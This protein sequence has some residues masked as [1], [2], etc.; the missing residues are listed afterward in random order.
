MASQTNFEEMTLQVVTALNSRRQL[1][2]IPER[3][4]LVDRLKRVETPTWRTFKRLRELEINEE[5]ILNYFKFVNTP[6]G[7][8]IAAE[9]ISTV[10]EPIQIIMPTRY[11]I[12]F[13]SQDQLTVLNFWHYNKV[14]LTYC[15]MRETMRGHLYCHID[16]KYLKF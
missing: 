3:E 1:T 11:S 9:L 15:G 13:N 6:F 10:G 8:A 14:I 5:Y 2:I 4:S 7:E 16:F 12:V